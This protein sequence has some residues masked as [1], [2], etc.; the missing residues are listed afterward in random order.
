MIIPVFQPLGSSSHQLAAR[1]GAIHQEKSTHTGTLDPL[2]EGVLV[3]LTGEDRF[4][5]STFSHWHKTYQF[6]AVFGLSTDSHDLLGLL[7]DFEPQL[8]HTP[9]FSFGADRALTAKLS[10]KLS[11][12]LEQLSGTYLQTVPDFSARRVAGQ[13][14]FDLA[15]QGRV[16]A[17]AREQV[18]IF[19]AELIGCQR[20]SLEKLCQT[21]ITRISKVSGDFRQAEITKQWRGLAEAGNSLE[22]AEIASPLDS[23]EATSQTEL[24]EATFEVVVS[25]RTY[26]RG[27]VRDLGEFLNVPTIT[28]QISRLKNG[29]HTIDQC[30]CISPR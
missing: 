8:S 6:S 18:E 16:I 14:A 13:S 5:K 22:S 25:R 24:L 12:W 17:P 21:A 23:L 30:I 27:L 20:I 29:P 1:V 7:T 19:R 11:V 9:L 28:T 10:A 15:K 26:I 4:Q 3:V 2:A